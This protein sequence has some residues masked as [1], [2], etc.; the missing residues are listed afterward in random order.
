MSL[1]SIAKHITGLDKKFTDGLEQID[2]HLDTLLSISDKSDLLKKGLNSLPDAAKKDLVDSM[3]YM[4]SKVDDQVTRRQIMSDYA[5]SIAPHFEKAGMGREEF[6]N[7]MLSFA[8]D[9]SARVDEIKNTDALRKIKTEPA[10][11]NNPGPLNAEKRGGN[12]TPTPKKPEAEPVERSRSTPENNNGGNN[13]SDRQERRSNTSTA[14]SSLSKDDLAIEKFT[15]ALS[16][17]KWKNRV[18]IDD[19]DEIER[20]LND[21]GLLRRST[22]IGNRSEEGRFDKIV[23]RIAAGEPISVAEFHRLKAGNPNLHLTT[24]QQVT[25]LP[26]NISN[27]LGRLNVVKGLTNAFNNPLQWGDWGTLTSRV[28]L[29]T[30]LTLGVPSAGHY[31]LN[32]DLEGASTTKRTVLNAAL[33]IPDSYLGFGNG[34]ENYSGNSNTPPIADLEFNKLTSFSGFR[35]NQYLETRTLSILGEKAGQSALK[36]I[37]EAKEGTPDYWKAALDLAVQVNAVEG[38]FSNYDIM[39]AYKQALGATFGMPS[40]QE[41]TSKGLVDYTTQQYIDSHA[42][43]LYA[44][45]NE[46]ERSERNNFFRQFTGKQPPENQQDWNLEILHSAAR[47]GNRGDPLLKKVATAYLLKAENLSE[48]DL[49]SSKIAETDREITE[50]IASN[51][52]MQIFKDQMQTV[53]GNREE[54][55]VRGR[56]PDPNAAIS[57][58]TEDNNFG[59]QGKKDFLEN[60]WSVSQN[61]GRVDP[62]VLD[63]KL[64]QGGASE[65]SRKVL[66]DMALQCQ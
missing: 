60:A 22:D 51:N 14:P 36:Q 48:A 56:C 8:E 42:R 64:Q 32:A 54:Q 39:Y 46:E 33:A 30:A 12:I 19:Y 2:N 21:R 62:E 3:A 20:I 45:S 38:K 35:E 26:S 13:S 65:A 9:V 34:L 27:A 63:Q 55:D 5:Q 66:H 24:Q 53:V 10:P 4:I 59:M 28:A 61:N 25:G 1:R 49:S 52:R 57:M 50:R 6:R 41:L 31:I 17:A 18:G 47:M 40:G 58:L 44:P 7:H 29:T 43:L 37:R 15:S 16:E 23:D 11:Y